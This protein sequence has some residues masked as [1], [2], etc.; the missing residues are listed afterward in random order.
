MEVVKETDIKE[1]PLHSRGKVRDIYQIDDHMLLI[2]TTDRMS[3]FDVIL[4]EPIPYKG[5]ILNNLTLF[6]MNTFKSRVPNHIIESNVSY[7]PSSLK[8]YKDILEG[9]S[10]LVKKATPLPIECIVRGYLSGSGWKDYSATGKVC[11]YRLPKGLQE[12][13]K[14]NPTLF[15][16][17][18]K[19]NFG[20]HDENIS[21]ETMKNLIGEKTTTFIVELSQF[22]FN[23]ATRWAELQ[24]I[25][26]ADTK[27]EFGLINGQ[28]TLIDEVLTPDSSRFWS[29][30]TYKAGQSQ[31]S[32]D[33]QYLRD[34]L[35]TQSWDKISP[36]PELPEDI[37][38]TTC[39]K[40][41]DAYSILTGNNIDI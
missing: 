41:Q 37:I 19:A 27:F 2:I 16:P 7:F 24:G 3:A 8:P 35:E 31:P 39:K 5:V 6:W 17:S 29:A 20:E 28:L 25:I 13:E 30:K 40:Y 34:W 33:K 9:R 12:S 21:M 15:T 23:E 32:F 14:L 11:G 18:T 1:F 10:V 38:Q 22:M 36:P 4:K 26:I